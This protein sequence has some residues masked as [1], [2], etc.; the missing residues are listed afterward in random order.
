MEVD[1]IIRSGIVICLD[2]GNKFRVGFVRSKIKYDLVLI[3]VLA[4]RD[5]E[6]LRLDQETV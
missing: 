4:R 2:S 5:P 3:R 1:I 6:Y